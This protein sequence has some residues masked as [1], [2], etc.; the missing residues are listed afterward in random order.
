M[1]TSSPA[2]QTVLWL[3]HAN[4]FLTSLIPSHHSCFNLNV[5]FPERP[6]L[7]TP[8]VLHPFHYCPAISFGSIRDWSKFIIIFILAYFFSLT[9]PPKTLQR[10]QHSVTKTMYHPQNLFSFLL[11]IEHLEVRL[12]HGHLETTCPGLPCN[13]TGWFI[14]NMAACLGFFPFAC[15]FW[16]KNGYSPIP[17]QFSE[18]DCLV[19]EEQLKNL[20]VITVGGEEKYQFCP[21]NFL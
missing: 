12:C 5:T 19:L 13:E 10:K 20:I 18:T 4:P 6:S 7:S 8:N 2:A 3:E 9:T 11:V 14:S 21:V 17:N 16:N 15:W 1:L